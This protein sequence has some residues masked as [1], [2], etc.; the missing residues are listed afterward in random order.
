M[1]YIKGTVSILGA[2][3][4]AMEDTMIKYISSV[5]NNLKIRIVLI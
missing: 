5:Y 3:V 1:F 4:A 2:L